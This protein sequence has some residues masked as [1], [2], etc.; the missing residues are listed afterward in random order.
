[1][2]GVSLVLLAVLGQTVG[3]DPLDLVPRLGA[4][5]FSDRENAAGRLEQLGR[6]SLNALHAARDAKDPEI[7]ARATALIGKIEASLLTKASLVR[8][9]FEDAP[10]PNVIRSFAEQTGIKL[11]LVPETSPLWAN[12]R[13]TLRAGAPLPFWKAID[14]LCE[15]ARLHYLEGTHLPG[16][17]E[18]TFPLFDGSDRPLMPVSDY[19]PFRVGVVGIHFQR[20]FSFVTPDQARRTR[21]GQGVAAKPAATLNEQFYV[22]LQVTAEPR[23]SVAQ[24]GTMTI[25]EALDE[26]GN[27]LINPPTPANGMTERVSGYFGFAPGPVVQ[28]QGALN[29]PRQAGATIKRLKGMIPL[30]VSM[31][32]ANPLVVALAGASGRTFQNDDVALTVHES[33]P[34]ENNRPGT[35]EITLRAPGGTGNASATDFSASD[36]A[37][38]PDVHQQQIEV[39]DGQGRLLPWYQSN[40][41]VEAGRLTMMF[42]AQ[43]PG[44]TPVELRYYGL[45]NALTEAPFEF[46]DL[47]LP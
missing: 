44:A 40:F 5:R 28:L 22:Q 3:A 46:A 23:L 38:R 25:T 45:T 19:G 1:M 21:P 29:R 15:A 42:P 32:K 33:K 43:E 9:D 26:R 47:P 12:R 34:P 14:R 41:D 13:V 20:D 4:P 39:V 16:G 11:S 30:A 17:R 2:S 24:G 8:L 18:P 7:R 37:V 35:L 36:L 27:R 10:L 31:R 6:A